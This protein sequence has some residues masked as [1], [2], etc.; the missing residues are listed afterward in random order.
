MSEIEL[1]TRENG[2]LKQHKI[3]EAIFARHST[4]ICEAKN[5]FVPDRKNGGYFGDTLRA[6]ITRLEPDLFPRIS[7]YVQAC[8]G[9]KEWGEKEW[10]EEVFRDIGDEIEELIE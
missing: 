9:K 4:A 5:A 8:G 10:G 7:A 3:A 2:S 6:L 1:V